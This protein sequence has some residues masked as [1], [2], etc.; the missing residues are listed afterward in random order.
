[1][2]LGVTVIDKVHQRVLNEGGKKYGVLIDD[3]ISDIKT[4]IFVNTDD[5]LK[6]Q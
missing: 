4:K 6:K 2:S 3:T 1:M 5:F